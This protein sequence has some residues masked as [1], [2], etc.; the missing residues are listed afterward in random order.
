MATGVKAAGW[1]RGDASQALPGKPAGARLL[2]TAAFGLLLLAL[3]WAP[4]PLGSNRQW[5]LALLGLLVWAGVLAAALARLLGPARGTGALA[6]GW[7]VPCAGLAGLAV[8]LVVQMLPGLGADGGALSVDVFHT[9]VYLFT[10]LVY[11]GAWL[12]VLLVVQHTERAVLVLGVMVAGGVLQATAAVLLYASGARYEL[13]HT[14]FDQGTRAMGSF[15]NADHLAC[16]MALGLSAGLGW[17]I[18]QLGHGPSRRAATWQARVVGAL[19]FLMS[20]KMLLRLV[21]VLLVLVLVMTHS[22]GGNGSFFIALLLV[23]GWVAWRSR[24]LRQPAL[25]LV[26]SMALVDVV[27][28]GQWVGLDRVVQR[29]SDTAQASLPAESAFGLG[30]GVAPREESLAQRLEVPAMSLAMV[31]QRPWLGHGGGTYYTAFPPYKTRDGLPWQW[32]HAHNDYVQVAADLGLVGLALWLTI[33]AA[34]A[35]RA[36]QLVQD[37]HP[38]ASR[39]V[40]VAALMTITYMAL[41]SMVDFNLQ[42]PANALMVTVLLAL[43]WLPHNP[44]RKPADDE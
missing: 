21:L 9:R 34:S 39:G 20:P 24:R 10:S 25:W 4:W 12:L 29:L 11:A 42:I 13:W 16:Y 31:Q 43:V 5:A 38:R 36:V 15:P 19:G 2:N 30:P 33:G 44:A 23:G 7:W 26:A 41:H 35:W 37:R 1:P 14:P 32:N 6:R 28:I 17:L 18:A 27:V 8:L 22:R 3:L 40:G